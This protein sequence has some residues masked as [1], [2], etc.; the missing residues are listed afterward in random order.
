MRDQK[1]FENNSAVGLMAGIAG[2]GRRKYHG[3]AVSSFAIRH[4][5]AARDLNMGM[6][7]LHTF[8]E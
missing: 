3:Q 2:P 7:L 6:L 4:R 5:E 1:D 8:C